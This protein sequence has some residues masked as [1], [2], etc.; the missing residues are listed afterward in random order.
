MSEAR[1]GIDK[2]IDGIQYDNK[3]IEHLREALRICAEYNIYQKELEDWDI[4]QR[5]DVID[6]TEQNLGVWIIN[7]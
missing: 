3:I 5:G 4:Y 1:D 2:N 6:A 7:Q